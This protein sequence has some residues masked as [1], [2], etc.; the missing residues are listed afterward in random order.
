MA[1]SKLPVLSEAEEAKL[2]VAWL[3]IRGYKFH[4]SPNE[5]GSS[6]EA[7][8][9]GIR[10]KQQGTSPGFP[11]YTILAGG[12]II[13]IELKSKKGYTSPAQKEWLVAINEID[14]VE[15][16]IC[17]GADEAIKVI[18]ECAPRNVPAKL[19]GSVF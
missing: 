1:V 6:P 13:F 10:M 14:N 12:H 9:R 8:R 16:F 5:T 19:A 11:D 15:G 2:L 3:R 4:H 17:R 7:R 18:E